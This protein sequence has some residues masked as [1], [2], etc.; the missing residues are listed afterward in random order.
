MPIPNI[1]NLSNPVGPLR[2]IVRGVDISAGDYEDTGGFLVQ[3]NQAGDLVVRFLEG[4]AD[5]TFTLI[6][7]GIVGMGNFPGLCRAV[8]MNSTITTIDVGKL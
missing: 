2:D 8:R 6:A 1:S 7:G 4:K 3:A 5:Q